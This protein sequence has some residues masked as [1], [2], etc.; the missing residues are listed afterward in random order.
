M[1]FDPISFFGGFIADS[2]MGGLKAY[3]VE[4]AYPWLREWIKVQTGTIH[5]CTPD[6][7]PSLL[8]TGAI[9]AGDYVEGTGFFS[10][11]TDSH[12]PRFPLDMD[13]PFVMDSFIAAME[14]EFSRGMP[15][16]I[17]RVLPTTQFPIRHQDYRVGF[18]YPHRM[19]GF[20]IPWVVDGT[21]K[22]LPFLGRQTCI[23]PLD[24]ADKLANRVVK[25][26]ARVITVRKD[27]I[28]RLF[29]PISDDRYEDMRQHGLLTFLS[30]VDSHTGIE[31]FEPS[32]FPFLIG[33]HFIETHWEQPEVVN[34][35]EFGPIL[36]RAIEEVLVAHGYPAPR[37][38]IGGG[39]AMPGQMHRWTL[40]SLTIV[41][42]RGL[43]Y[44]HFQ[45]RTNLLDKE[46][47]KRDRDLFEVVKNG[48]IGRVNDSFGLDTR[49]DLNSTDNYERLSSNTILQST[50]AR[51]LNSPVLAGVRG[52]LERKNHESI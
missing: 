21:A 44:F 17:Y 25:Y 3:V 4:T 16:P 45:I 33:S 13:I 37:Y 26:H 19:P 23:V 11:Y 47:S 43:P 41:Q 10:L 2:L 18:L 48:I 51:K 9:K 42:P 50:A 34:S 30:A 52:W 24:V 36:N 12:Q 5:V 7:L 6:E 31:D 15:N 1:V 20:G 40:P 46:Q 27:D 49:Q 32:A 35:N 28:D 22:T 8:A 38:S 14:D 29:G 39:K